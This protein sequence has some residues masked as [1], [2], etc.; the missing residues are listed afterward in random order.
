MFAVCLTAR[1]I[2][3]P[4]TAGITLLCLM[5]GGLPGCAGAGGGV[6]AEIAPKLRFEV[7]A[8]RE[9]GYT[10]SVV[11]LVTARYQGEAQLF[12][13]HLAISPERLTMIAVDALGRRAFTLAS[14]GTGLTLDAAPWMSP[15]LK[16]ANI[17]ADLAIVYWP[18][19]AVRHALDGSP[20]V[21][22]SGDHERTILAD[23]REI[24]H[25]SYDAPLGQGWAGAAHYRNDAFGYE[26]DL[27]SRVDDR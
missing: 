19:R 16:A 6:E 14:D 24:I 27:R 21:L 17:L 2:A 10:V 23:G 11:Q 20:A 7:P 9:L 15:G 8:P 1:V 5:A 4:R 25:V 22:K 18:E 12:E 13:A 3:R 26:L